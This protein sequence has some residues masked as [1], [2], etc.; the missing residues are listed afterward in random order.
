LRKL[1]LK[2]VSKAIYDEDSLFGETLVTD[3]CGVD[4]HYL[5][6]RIVRAVELV[7]KIELPSAVKV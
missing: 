6:C 2:R 1:G 7:R 5:G 3:K 4:L